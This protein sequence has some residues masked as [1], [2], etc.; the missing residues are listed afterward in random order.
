M[1]WFAGKALRPTF[2]NL[3]ESFEG[4]TYRRG[5]MAKVRRLETEGLLESSLDPAT[6]KHLHRLT[7]AGMRVALGTRDPETCWSQKWDRKWR[8]LLF[9]IPERDA[10]KRRELRRALTAAGFGCLQASVWIS[11]SP[12]PDLSKV[13]RSDGADCSRIISLEADS[14]GLAMDKRMV[15]TAWNFPAI[16]AKYRDYMKFQE[17]FRDVQRDPSAEKLGEWCRAEFAEWKRA[18]A[19]DPLLPAA[20][21]PRDYLGKKALHHR[22]RMLDELARLASHE[23]S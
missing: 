9:D 12:P 20:L 18:T 19:N 23:A 6:G 8:L 4:W 13:Q 11:P 10:S 3:N 15:T 7:E 1:L 16:N 14:K 17:K 22:Q 2:R 5:L 21:I